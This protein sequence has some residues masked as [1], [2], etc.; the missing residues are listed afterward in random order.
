M[1]V[2]VGRLEGG[3]D[4]KMGVSSSFHWLKAAG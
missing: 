2:G 1:L 3:L 4:Q